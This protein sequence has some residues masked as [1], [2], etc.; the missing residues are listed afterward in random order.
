MIKA[1]IFDYT[2]VFT[3]ESSLLD[4]CDFYSEK[5]NLNTDQ[6]KELMIR[7]WLEARVS[8]IESDEFWQQLASYSN[9]EISKFRDDFINFF[10]FRNELYNFVVQNLKDNYKLGMLSN[11]IESWFEPV[12]KAKK[13]NDIFDVIVTSYGSK[14][15]KPDKRIFEKIISELKLEPN[16]CIYIDDFTKNIL[17]AK[18]IGMST[19]L[20]KDF[21]QFKHELNS[22]LSN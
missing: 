15:A 16:E 12:I 10:G 20:F 21:E 6:M 22:I 1:I 13:F 8:N 14:L 3:E 18:E 2:G 11:Q 9:Q 19:I 17:P 5:Y 4:F 7:L